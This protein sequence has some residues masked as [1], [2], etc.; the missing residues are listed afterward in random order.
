MEHILLEVGDHAFQQHL[1]CL[2]DAAA[3]DHHLR[4]HHA[5]DVAQQHAQIVV[6]LL[7]NGGGGRVTGLGRVKNVLAGQIFR[8][9]QFG[10][11]GESFR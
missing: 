1:S 9:L 6:H 10:G 3:D 8:V 7:Q 11:Q 5:A 2:A 4:I